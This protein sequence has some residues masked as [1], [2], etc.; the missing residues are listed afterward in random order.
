MRWA[1]LSLRAKNGT[2]LCINISNLFFVSQSARRVST[3]QNPARPGPRVRVVNA[4]LSPS[5]PSISAFPASAQQ[6]P[7]S[8]P[9]AK[10]SP[11]GRGHPGPISQNRIA[12]RQGPKS[13]FVFLCIV[14]RDT[15]GPG[16]SGIS[17]PRSE[18]KGRTRQLDLDAQSVADGRRDD[19][20]GWGKESRMRLAV[21]SLLSG[22]S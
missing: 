14:S 17:Q 18:G 5:L 4:A 1:S 6:C 13:V 3:D 11:R 19:D 21:V 15:S 22:R 10:P 20:D 9:D 2:T 8:P 7:T 16:T 12:R